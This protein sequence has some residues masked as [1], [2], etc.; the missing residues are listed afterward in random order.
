MNASLLV[1]PVALMFD[2]D[3]TLVDTTSII[4]KATEKTFE[5]MGKTSADISNVGHEGGKSMPDFFRSVFGGEWEKASVIYRDHYKQHR[6]AHVTPLPGSDA[7][8]RQLAAA[9]PELYMAVVSNKLGS[10][11][12]DEVEHFQ[13]N[14]LFQ[15]VVGS[16]DAPADKPSGE[17]VYHALL[18][19]DIQPGPHVW[20]I[21]DSITDLECAKNSGCTAILYDCNRVAADL[22]P[23]YKPAH[24]VT[25]HQE[26][27]Q[28]LMAALSV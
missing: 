15:A 14:T 3:N 1:K 10:F 5:V 2:W 6:F 28:V 19:T 20:F 23:R 21:G 7:M 17:P 25:S 4:K 26:L 11:L 22:I 16:Q 12:R 13:W 8:L 18:G 24:Y 9:F 27:A